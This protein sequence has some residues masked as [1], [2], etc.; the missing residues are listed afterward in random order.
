M[1]WFFFLIIVY[2][3][4]CKTEHKQN[5]HLPF[6][7][8]EI[9]VLGTELRFACPGVARAAPSSPLQQEENL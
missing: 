1:V 6:T 3:T 7:V 4:L 2:G 5:F 9:G 8:T